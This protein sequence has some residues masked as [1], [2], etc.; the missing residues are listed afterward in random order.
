MFGGTAF[1]NSDEMGSSAPISSELPATIP[2]GTVLSAA[3][4]LPTVAAEGA[5][6][7]WISDSAIHCEVRARGGAQWGAREGVGGGAKGWR[8][9]LME[10]VRGGVGG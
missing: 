4:K 5:S 6:A 2:V 10:G 1:F 3:L 8:G 9:A 7:A